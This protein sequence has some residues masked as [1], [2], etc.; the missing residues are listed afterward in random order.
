MTIFR[1]IEI[2]ESEETNEELLHEAWQ[3]LIDTG[4][5][6]NLQGWYG[7]QAMRLLR[8]GI[9]KMPEEILDQDVQG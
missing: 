8:E 1:A 6:W 2:I 7:R 5:C 3:F 4:T 9:C